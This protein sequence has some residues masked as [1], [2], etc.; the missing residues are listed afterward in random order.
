MVTRKA[1]KVLLGPTYASA[2]LTIQLTMNT[3]TTK[4]SS[5]ATPVK[6]K[7]NIVCMGN[8]PEGFGRQGFQ[9]SRRAIRSAGKA[10]P[11]MA[12]LGQS[13]NLTKKIILHATILRTHAVE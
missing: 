3:V 7:R 13:S 10:P 4:G 8:S 2:I 5:V 12:T 6:K 11:I 9:G 1:P